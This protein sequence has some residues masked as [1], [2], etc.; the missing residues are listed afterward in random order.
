[1]FSNYF[2][3]VIGLVI[4]TDRSY[5]FFSSGEYYQ[6]EIWF[7]FDSF[8]FWFCIISKNKVKKRKPNK[9]FY[10]I[11]VQIKFH[12]EGILKSFFVVNEE[13]GGWIFFL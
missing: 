1:M 11:K 2:K 10:L 6:L 9:P 4:Y 3:S 13:V 7:I 5:V 12:P 8:F